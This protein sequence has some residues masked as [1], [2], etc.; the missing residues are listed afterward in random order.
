VNI[1]DLLKEENYEGEN[2]GSSLD[3]FVSTFLK[4]HPNIDNNDITSENARK[5]FARDFDEKLKS[6]F[7][8]DMP[9]SCLRVGRDIITKKISASFSVGATS[10]D[11]SYTINVFL[12]APVDEENSVKLKQYTD[13][14]IKGIITRPKDDI[15]EKYDLGPTHV[16]FN[17]ENLYD[18]RV[19]RYC[20][21]INVHR[22]KLDLKEFTEI[23]QSK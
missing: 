9:F 21:K 1:D 23:P 2:V 19:L 20:T 5:D 3:V 6:S 8:N 4:S 14:K 11:S 18:S 15:D 7:L 22:L 13:Y 12:D 17:K 10:K 16:S